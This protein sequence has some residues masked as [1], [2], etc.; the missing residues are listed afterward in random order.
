MSNIKHKERI[1]KVARETQLVTDK[2]TSIEL[3]TDLSAET[4]Q[5]RGI[6]QY[7][8]SAERKKLPT[9]NSLPGR[10]IIQK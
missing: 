8:Q 6:A 7:I 5:T 2:G 9:K 10:V 3:S 4:L 1:I